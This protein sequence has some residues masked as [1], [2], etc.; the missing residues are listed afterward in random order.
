[1]E[2]NKTCSRLLCGIFQT[3]GSLE[4]IETRK[5]FSSKKMSF[6]WRVVFVVGT[7][8]TFTAD[9]ILKKKISYMIYWYAIYITVR[10]TNLHVFIYPLSILTIHR[11]YNIRRITRSRMGNDV[12]LTQVGVQTYMNRQNKKCNSAFNQ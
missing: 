10:L 8:A 2:E 1:M 7:S 3:V 11:D 9:S 5:K 4:L 12:T 6:Y